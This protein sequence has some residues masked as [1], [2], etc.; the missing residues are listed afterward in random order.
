MHCR[1]TNLSFNKLKGYFDPGGKSGLSSGFCDGPVSEVCLDDF[2]EFPA[3]PDLTIPLR[4]GMNSDQLNPE[5]A[6]LMLLVMHGQ[7]ESESVIT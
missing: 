7:N 4:G 2:E 6:I 5:R 1:A 3:F